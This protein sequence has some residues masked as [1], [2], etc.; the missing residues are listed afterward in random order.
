MLR[1][2]RVISESKFSFKNIYLAIEHT[3]VDIFLRPPS[4]IG[5]KEHLF[6]YQKVE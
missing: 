2:N 6:K 1:A 5:R 3:I 4:L